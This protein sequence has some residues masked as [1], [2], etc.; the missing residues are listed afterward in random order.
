M[1]KA[2]FAE[3]FTV[4]FKMVSHN[5]PDMLQCNASLTVKNKRKQQKKRDPGYILAC[6]RILLDFSIQQRGRRYV[7]A[8]RVVSAVRDKKLI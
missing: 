5:S 7:T 4:K 1:L 3:I 2:D 8:M 6:S